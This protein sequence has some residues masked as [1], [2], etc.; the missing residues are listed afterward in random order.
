MKYQFY[1][2]DLHYGCVVATDD[3]EKAMSL[4]HS[5]DHFVVNSETGQSLINGIYRN[6]VNLDIIE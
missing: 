5:E 2:T 3:M 4:S 1:V 6:V